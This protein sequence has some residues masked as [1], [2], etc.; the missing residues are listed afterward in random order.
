MVL[1]RISPAS[2]RLAETR[3]RLCPDVISNVTPEE[4]YYGADS[5]VPLHTIAFHGN[6]GF[7]DFESIEIYEGKLASLK[8]FKDDVKEVKEGHFARLVTFSIS[9]MLLP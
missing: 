6:G 5:G 2:S 3:F 7:V 1:L 8:R 4:S 9:C